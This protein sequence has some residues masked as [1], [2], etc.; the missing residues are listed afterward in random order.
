MR[1]SA[2]VDVKYRVAISGRRALCAN[3]GG[4][5]FPAMNRCN[6]VSVNFLMRAKYAN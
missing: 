4:I 3:S 2:G 1:N 5:V 6:S